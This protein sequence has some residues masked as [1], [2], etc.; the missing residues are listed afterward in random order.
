MLEDYLKRLENLIT[1]ETYSKA[2]FKERIGVTSNKDLQASPNRDMILEDGKRLI[3]S[4]LNKMGVN[5]EQDQ[6]A[7]LSENKLK[8]YNKILE[9]EG[10]L[11]NPPED[12]IA[13]GS[14]S[15]TLRTTRMFSPIKSR[16]S[17]L[18]DS[19]MKRLS[20]SP[21]GVRDR[22]N[23]EAGTLREKIHNLNLKNM[24]YRHEVETLK[25]TITGLQKELEEQKHFVY[26]LERQKENDNKYLL[27]L[28]S[29]IQ[30][31]RSNSLLSYRSS[32]S[33]NG[34]INDISRIT[35]NQTAK[36]KNTSFNDLFSVEISKNNILIEEKGN[37][38]ILNVND[39]E[40]LRILVLN[41]LTENKRLKDFQKEVFEISR[42]YDNINEGMMEAIK[43]LQNLI[44]DDHKLLLEDTGKFELIS[45][46]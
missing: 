8:V 41:L 23:E 32:N 10:K 4:Y 15:N 1:P 40:E 28:E 26:K 21:G 6:K 16:D 30:N 34:A 25:N 5:R 42:N 29:M 22:D 38:N 7:F 43:N 44:K 2:N 14:H 45:K 46:C 33:P 36:K 27:K 11:E 20:F 39:K 12:N 18:G 13:S 17:Q 3:D 24:N 19:T 31:N 37:H 35:Y 9:S